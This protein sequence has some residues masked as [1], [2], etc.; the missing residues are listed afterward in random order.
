[1]K[2]AKNIPLLAACFMLACALATAQTAAPKQPQPALTVSGQISIGDRFI[3]FLIH[4]LPPS[5]FPALPRAVQDGLNRRGC[6][7]PQ[8]YEAHRPEN[9]IHADFEGLGGED[10]ATLCAVQGTV[11]LLVFFDG[12]AEPAVLASAPATERLQ[13]HDPSGVLGFN[14]GIDPATPK[15]I[16]EAQR[17]MYPRPAALDHDALA[18]TIVEHKTVYHF[19][20]KGA[21]TLVKLPD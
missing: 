6:M 5:S 7:I 21:W 17:G 19:Y 18:D 1:M 8:T 16:S 11:S 2:R 10:W 3:S 14:W 13:A 12:K 9:V 20:A 4:Q 15:Q